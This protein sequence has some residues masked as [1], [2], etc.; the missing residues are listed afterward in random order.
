MSGES[1]KAFELYFILSGI[2]GGVLS[3]ELAL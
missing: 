2:E 3:E 1:I